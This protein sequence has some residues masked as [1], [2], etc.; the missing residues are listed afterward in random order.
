MSTVDSS[1]LRES[2][3]RRLSAPPARL[4]LRRAR[5]IGA[6][7]LTI[8]VLAAAWWLLAPPK[9]GGSTSFT[10]VDGSSMLPKLERSDLVAVREAKTYEV[11]D[12]V[13]YRSPLIH[14]VVLHRIVRIRADGHYVLKGDHNPYLDPDH[15]ER[16]QIVG[17][18]W[19]TI[20]TAGRAVAAL[21]VPWVVA[22]V[23]AL[24]VLWLGLGAKPPAD[25]RRE[26]ESAP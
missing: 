5:S 6:F 8:V 10:E 19:F 12:I 9:F 13:A 23:A 24:L 11:G 1:A 16:S 26:E 22:A 17:K 4:H 21:H 3:A 18:L 20:P 14:R 7:L 15:P 25:R 2:V